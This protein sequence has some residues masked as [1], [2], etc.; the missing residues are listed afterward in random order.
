MIRSN[1]LALALLMLASVASA[2]SSVVLSVMA[3]KQTLSLDQRGRGTYAAV[4]DQERLSTDTGLGL[5]LAFGS[6]QGDVR[7]LLEA[8]GVG[9]QDVFS[10][11]VY[12]LGVEKFFALNSVKVLRPFMGVNAGFGKLDVDAGYSV[13]TRSGDDSG[14]V[15]GV[16][17]GVQYV[18]TPTV[19]LE[20]RL[21]YLRTDLN[22]QLNGLPGSSI[23]FA[24]DDARAVSAGV[25]F[26][27]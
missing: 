9:V 15:Y 24:V 20:A 17:G 25:S 23:M 26:Q 13:G 14:F 6:P 21:R 18:L 3:Q 2:Q 22:A 10:V 1:V 27:F 11:D 19:A 12:T 5:G 7:V 16:S 4:D 8:A